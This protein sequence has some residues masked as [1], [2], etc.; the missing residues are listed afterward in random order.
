VTPLLAVDGLSLRF[1]G[2]AALSSV[3]FEVGAGERLAVIGPNGAGK[4]SVL[5]CVSGA[6]RPSSGTITVNGRDVARL[7]PAA[8]AAAGVARTLQ[9]LA[10]VDDLDVLANLLLGRHARTRSGLVSTA[11]GL[12][13]ARTEEAAA[14]HRCKEIAAEL[15]LDELLAVRAGDLPAGARKRVELGRALAMDATLLLLDEPFAGAGAEEV[16][17]MAAAIRGA[18]AGVVVVDHNL[19]AVTGLVDRAVV[20][21]A[22]RVV[23]VGP[24]SDVARHPVVAGAA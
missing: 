18:G 20:L 9:S 11:L 3:S 1:G 10:V 22:G 21:D 5:N 19:G 13:R 7:R 23:A 4:T 14:R 6:Q 15:D 12:A 2:V 17:V 16:E 24:P 8:R